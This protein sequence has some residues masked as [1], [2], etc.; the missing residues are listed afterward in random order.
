MRGWTDAAVSPHDPPAARRRAVSGYESWFMRAVHPEQPVGLW[1]RHTSHKDPDGQV[2]GAY[3]LTLFD[4]QGVQARKRAVP[5][6]PPANASH[7]EGS[8]GDAMW[9]L[10]TTGASVALRHLPAD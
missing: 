6:R 2:T 1:V 9:D 3:W 5:N 8:A 4:G 10:R 7:F